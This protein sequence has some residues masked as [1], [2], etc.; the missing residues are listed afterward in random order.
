M[1]PL[2]NAINKMKL[3]SLIGEIPNEVYLDIIW[4]QIIDILGYNP[5]TM[6][7]T[8]RYNGNNSSILYTDRRPITEVS[9]ITI[10]GKVIDAEDYEINDTYIRF[11]ERC[12]YAYKKICDG[13]TLYKYCITDEIVL[14]Y[15]SGYPQDQLPGKIIMAASMLYKLNKD[16]IGNKANL[17]SYG[18]DTIKYT[19]K[20]GSDRMTEIESLLDDLKVIVI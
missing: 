19:Y 2:L 15:T 8:E 9:E 13:D 3:S 12:L 10:N 16:N 14:T 7:T 20:D 4:E 6:E 11:L 1:N 18:I 17:T 5:I